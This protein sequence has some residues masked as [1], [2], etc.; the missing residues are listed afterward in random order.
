M[1]NQ[2]MQDL[3]V[4]MDI[5]VFK[6]PCELVDLRFT[7]KKGRQHTVER[8]YLKDGVI[9]GPMRTQR[10][11]KDVNAALDNGEGCKVVGTFYLHFLAN[12]FHIQFGNPRLMIQIMKLRKGNLLM[13]LSHKINHL[14]FGPDHEISR[15]SS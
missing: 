14:S 10:G 11:V 13:D 7:S 3:M 9:S 6:V 2:K 15:L 4:N 8:H 1:I 5:D 12:E